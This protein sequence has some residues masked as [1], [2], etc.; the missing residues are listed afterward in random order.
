MANQRVDA[1]LGD[2]CLSVPDRREQ[3]L[4]REHD[5]RLRRQLVEQFEFVRRQCHLGA[6][7]DGVFDRIELKAVHRHRSP[8][9]RPR[10]ERRPA[11]APR[12]AATRAVNSR[13]PNGLVT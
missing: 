10:L 2:E 9:R 3:L 6:H 7:A 12:S 8:D 11:H 5:A 13:T 1:A 4:A